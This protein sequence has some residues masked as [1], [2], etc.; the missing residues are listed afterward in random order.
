MK[1]VNGII[2]RFHSIQSVQYYRI[3]RLIKFDVGGGGGAWIIG[4]FWVWNWLDTALASLWSSKGEV[5][6][7]RIYF[8]QLDGIY[9]PTRFYDIASAGGRKS[10]VG[11]VGMFF[12]DD[13]VFSLRAEDELGRRLSKIA[14]EQTFFLCL[15]PVCCQKRIGLGFVRWLW[16]G[17]IKPKGL[18]GRWSWMF[19]QLYK[20][21]VATCPTR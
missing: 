5:H 19:P 15:W 3:C 11:V 21:W 10:W 9:F 2:N 1:C 4:A 16:H 14:E 13:N 20:R 12:F 17:N 8:S 7:G 6:E 18:P